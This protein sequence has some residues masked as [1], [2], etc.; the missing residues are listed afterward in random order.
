[1]LLTF[2]IISSLSILIPFLVGLK[3]HK[4]FRSNTSKTFFAFIVLTTIT[5]IINSSFCFLVM[6]NIWLNNLYV[7]VP[8]I[9][10]Q[11]ILFSEKSIA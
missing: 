4:S 10:F 3:F 6:N 8:L 5:E 2:A 7:F 11:I 9:T 1:M